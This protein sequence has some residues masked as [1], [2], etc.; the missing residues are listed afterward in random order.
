MSE[1][2]DIIARNVAVVRTFLRG[3]DELDVDLCM[4]QCTEDMIYLNQ[5]LEAIKGKVNVRRMIASIFA[6]SKRKP[7]FKILNIFGYQNKVIAE[8]LD[9][10]DWDDTGHWQLQLP[11]CGMFELTVNG[12]IIEW[13][14]YYDNELWSKQ[15]GPSLTF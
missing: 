11:V 14:E 8:R 4:S 10:W 6:P 7:E 15:G 13:R 3:W 2:Q 5:P 9:Q 12:R 1:E